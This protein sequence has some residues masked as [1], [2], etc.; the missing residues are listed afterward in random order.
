MLTTDIH[1]HS[2]FSPDG[3]APLKDMLLSAKARGLRYFGIS[4]H[5][6]LD[7]KSIKRYGRT[8][9]EAY[10]RCARELQS[11]FNN[12]NFTFLSGG[13]FGFSED[14][15]VWERM[16]QIVKQFRPDFVINSV[17]AVKGVDCYDGVYFDDKEKHEAYRN[18]L[19]TVIRSLDVTYHYD[20]IGH[21][22]Y[23]SRKSP[24][25]DKKIRYAEFAELYDEILKKIIA[26][27]KI[28]EVNSS[29]REAGSDFLPDIDVL[30]RYFE[31]GGRRISFGSDAHTVE[32]IAEKRE[33]VC[34][35]LRKIGFSCITVPDKGKYVEITIE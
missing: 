18:Y 17:H 23:V 4:E 24:Y 14:E 27:G 15:S 8:D 32:R 6:D 34:K 2:T 19:E 33:L 31:L 28:L 35:E 20:I 13:E 26:K 21:L 16:E 5:F 11:R 9:A 3:K 29:S 7:E 30:H 12:A 10:F 25:P 1:A 22:G